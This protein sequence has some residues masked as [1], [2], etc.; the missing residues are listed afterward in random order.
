[1]P[2]TNKPLNI[3]CTPRLPLPIKMF[4][5][6]FGCFA[7]RE[8]TTLTFHT[9][10][11]VAIFPCQIASIFVWQQSCFMNSIISPSS[12]SS[13][14][15]LPFHA[16]RRRVNSLCDFSWSTSYNSS[17]KPEELCSMFLFPSANKQPPCTNANHNRTLFKQSGIQL[18]FFSHPL[19]LLS[20]LSA[21]FLLFLHFVATFHALKSSLPQSVGARRR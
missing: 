1:M 5:D 13:S 15:V 3:A 21:P 18:S 19:F 20:S 6:I 11:Y 8:V 17:S 12:A 4:V 10:V 14:A 2:V 7:V 16:T 9:V